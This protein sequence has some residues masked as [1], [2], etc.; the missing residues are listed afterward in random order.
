MKAWMV[1]LVVTALLGAGTACQRTSSPSSE[2][3]MSTISDEASPSAELGGGGNCPGSAP[4]CEFDEVTG[5]CRIKMI[6]FGTIWAC[7]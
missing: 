4:C 3:S 7:P 2:E 6:C 1:S 5:A